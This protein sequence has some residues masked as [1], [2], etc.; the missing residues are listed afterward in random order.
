VAGLLLDKGAD[1]QAMSQVSS[2]PAVHVGYV[3]FLPTYL[4]YPCLTASSAS[5]CRI[6]KHR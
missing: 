2:I 1:T 3:A 4:L 5:G 6:N